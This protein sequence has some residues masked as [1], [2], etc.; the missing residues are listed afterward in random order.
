MIS[1]P[2]TLRPDLPDELADLRLLALDLR[3]SWSHVADELWRRIDATLWRRTRNPWLILQ[4][5]SRRRLHHLAGD[6][7][8]QQLLEQLKQDQ[9]QA[10]KSASWFSR[11]YADRDFSPVAYFCM[12]YGLSEA[13][14]LYSGGLGVLAGDHLKTCSD[15]GVPLVAV[16]L[17][18]QQGYFRQGINAE[19]EQS[20]FYPFNDPTQMPVSPV[21][22]RDGEWLHISLPLP[23]RE[24]RLR[25][26][27]VQVGRVKLYLLDT[28]DPLNPPADRGISSEL[29]G[30]GT[31]LRLQQELV[32]GTGGWRM[33]QALGY[34]VD[35]CHMN[36]GHAAFA[37]IERLCG[38]MQQ[39]Q[40]DFDTA[41]SATRAGN[42]F[43]SHTP[44]EAGFDRFSNQ[45][46]VRHLQ[47]WIKA[48]GISASRLLALGHSQPEADHEAFNMAWLA[49]N[50]S[51]AVNGV[52][53]LHGRVSRKLFQP[54]FPRWPQYEVPVGHVTNGIHVPSWDSEDSD[55]FWTETC[56][57]DRW[58][59]QEIESLHV[60]IDEVSDADLWE[61]RSRNRQHFIEW[62]RQRQS[63]RLAFQHDMQ[64]VLDANVLTLGFARR[65]ATYK[66]PNLL[67]HDKQ[68]LAHL[69]RHKDQPIQLVIAGKAHPQDK[70]GQAMIREWVKFIR[71]Y[72]ACRHI[73]F[74]V[75]YDLLTAGHLVAGVDLW[76]NTPR[77]PWE[78]CGTSGMKIL[79]NGGLNFSERDGWWAEAWQEDL[80]WALGDGREH[81]DEPS[82]DAIEAEQMYNILEQQIIPTFYS[83]NQQGIPSAW[84]SKIRASMSAL[85]PR[86]SANRM[87]R[88]YLEEQ[89]LPL[90][91][92]ARQR[93]ANKARISRELCHWQQQLVKH[94]DDIHFANVKLERQ[95]QQIQVEAQLY[96]D[97]LDP[98]MVQLELYADP[99]DP[100]SVPERHILQQTDKL[101]GALNGYSYQLKIPAERSPGDYSLRVVPCHP[102]ARIP[103]EARQILWWHND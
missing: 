19:G 70:A 27:Q 46:V 25:C 18:Y 28:N 17:L 58:R 10:L 54:L 94:W 101:A 83:R 36:E 37:A 99:L 56:S 49:I 41:L 66:R 32:L 88:Q 52:S 8:F 91:E 51:G 60:S 23:G 30:G 84:V 24:L 11:K 96:L 93:R 71:D 6:N 64:N 73:V 21:R 55:R 85:T 82:W 44:V 12:E 39:Q 31:E 63:Y 43:T 47:P 9:Q 50:T 61:M 97:E 89:Y 62:L 59:N 16:G 95:G 57:K 22:D 90:A 15:L 14:P 33:L 68:R 53:R 86:F 1:A 75:D 102:N 3:W 103:L 98:Q 38:F 69:L 78:A 65:F 77:R 45:M 67:L 81:G 42:L 29:Y 26:W 4:T 48:M 87:L 100:L 2:Y 7:D 20:A 34:Q 80:G 79:V 92:A 40:V 35:V 5:V 13:L 74:L 72:D 76:L